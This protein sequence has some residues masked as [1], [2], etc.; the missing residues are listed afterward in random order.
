MP[1][2]LEKALTPRGVQTAKPGM[3]ADGGNLYLQVTEAK[4]GGFNRSWVFRYG[5]P[6]PDGKTR[7]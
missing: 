1:R 2:K 6:G 4:N 5:V 7:A 3:W